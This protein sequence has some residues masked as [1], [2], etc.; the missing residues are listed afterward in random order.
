ML[1]FPLW[2]VFFPPQL[3][4]WKCYPLFNDF[5]LDLTS[6][7]HTHTH[8]QD[9]NQTKQKKLLSYVSHVRMVPDHHYWI[10]KNLFCFCVK[11]RSFQ[12][13]NVSEL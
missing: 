3:E 6:G 9:Q 10:V 4:K 7:L 5:A 13:V 8:T 12:G 2:S 11:G 1:G